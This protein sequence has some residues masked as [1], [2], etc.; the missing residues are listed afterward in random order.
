M[1]DLTMERLSLVTTMACNLNCKLCGTDAPYRKGE[2]NFTIEQQKAVIEKYF[3][4]VSYVRKFSLTGGESLLYR[5]LPALLLHLK[6]YLDHIGIV[7]V[8]TNGTICPGEELIEIC[9]QFH[10]KITFLVDDYGNDLSICIAEIDRKLSDANIPHTIRDNK[11]EVSH[12]G[13]WVEFGDPCKQTNFSKHDMEVLF[14][15]CA[16]VQKMKFCFNTRNG[17]MYPCEHVRRC[18]QFGVTPDNPNEYVDLLD[19]TLTV[20]DL[21]KKII[22]IYHL[23]SLSACAYCKGMCE[24]SER[25]PPAEQLTAEELN[26]VRKGARSYYEV[27]KLMDR[28][29]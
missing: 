21:R 26:F 23:K 19:N 27:R 13:G 2:Y 15:K 6:K 25:F 8:I 4:I 28:A 18:I 20:D 5:D 17:V 29:E 10:E 1:D 12:C 24:D 22:N 9:K 3:S 11:A 14:S 7:E 16:L